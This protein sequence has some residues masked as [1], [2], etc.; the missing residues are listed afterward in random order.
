[1]FA[2]FC[3]FYRALFFTAARFI[4]IA[5]IYSAARSSPDHHPAG[6]RIWAHSRVDIDECTKREARCYS[7]AKARARFSR[8]TSL[9]KR[10]GFSDG[11]RGNSVLIKVREFHPDTGESA[12]PAALRQSRHVFKVSPVSKTSLRREVRA[13]LR[14]PERIFANSFLAGFSTLRS[15]T[16]RR[17]VS[18]W[19]NIFVPFPS[20]IPLLRS[21]TAGD[22]RRARLS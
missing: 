18:S 4:A 11:E 15:D 16:S 3:R 20:A 8:D 21:Q 10:N 13:A 9:A 14:S 19:N 17:N 1:M 22:T 7:I 12:C 5:G 2:S 6:R